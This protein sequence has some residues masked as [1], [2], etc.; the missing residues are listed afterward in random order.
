M[1]SKK[2][3]SDSLEYADGIINTVREPL[4]TL[5]QDLRVITANR[6]FYETFKV[7]PEE[8][9]GQLI[10]DLGNKQWDI[11]KLRDEKKRADEALR[12][13]IVYQKAIFEMTTVATAI[14][15]EDTTILMV[16]GEFEKLSGY[17]KAE[18]EGKKSW[19]EFVLA[20]DLKKM[21]YFH[22]QRRKDPDS[23]E[24]VYEFHAITKAGDI[25]T[26]LLNVDLIP[27]TKQSVISLLDISDRKKAEQELIDSEQKFKWLYIN[28]PIAYHILS[29][30]GII[31]DVNQKWCVVLKYSK[32]EVIGKPIFDFIHEDERQAAKKSF[33]N[34]KTSKQKY[35]EGGKRKYCTKAGEIRTFKTYDFFVLD[36]KGQVSFVQTTIQDITDSEL[37]NE[38]L[39][40]SEDKYHSVVEDTLGLI[41]RFLPDGTIIFANQ[42][43]CKFFGKK[44]DELI[45]TKIQSAIPEEER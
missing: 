3:E 33:E 28:A 9:V 42:A 2:T 1:N 27:G 26:I 34:K 12:E 14:I 40:K 17:T 32:E 5:D 30:D 7:K 15:E 45:G 18:L 4:I 20:E 36:E 25:K 24:K 11:P 38:K 19:T 22:Q 43:Y 8:T 39:Q 44:Q 23:V 16:N 21:E 35:F 37:A 13:S 41:D 6:S 10:Y 31:T 29:S